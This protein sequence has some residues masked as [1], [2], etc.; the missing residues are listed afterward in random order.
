MLS[1]TKEIMF[2]IDKGVCKTLL[3]IYDGEFLREWS[4]TSFYVLDSFT[5]TPVPIY[6]KFKLS[7]D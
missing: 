5:L 4:T 7:Q 3:G 2:T 6:C 1:S